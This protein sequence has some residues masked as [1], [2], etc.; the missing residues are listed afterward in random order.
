MLL[1]LV[2]LQGLV[3]RE[4][5]LDRPVVAGDIGDPAGSA[6]D[7]SGLPRPADHGRHRQPQGT[8][9]QS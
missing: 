1:F 6:R 4:P 2:G 7:H 8:Q 5:W 9:T 3:P